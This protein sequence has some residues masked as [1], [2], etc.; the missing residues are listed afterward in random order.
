MSDREKYKLLEHTLE[1]LL[2]QLEDHGG[3]DIVRE[4]IKI[5]LETVKNC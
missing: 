1:E 5:K 4:G 3:F 2:S